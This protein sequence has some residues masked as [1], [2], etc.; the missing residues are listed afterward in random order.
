MKITRGMLLRWLAGVLLTLLIGII[1]LLW[2]RSDFPYYNW[3]YVFGF[4]M[5]ITFFVRRLW[6]WR[7]TSRGSERKLKKYYMIFLVLYLIA[8]ILA[9]ANRMSSPD[10]VLSKVLG[11]IWSLTP[12][13][14]FVWFFISL[15][16][17]V[18]LL[19]L[20]FTAGCILIARLETR[21]RASENIGIG[22]S[23][24]R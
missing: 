16:V 8:L 3:A 6:S 1:L 13:Q 2:R 4:M 15:I 17:L 24:C 20:I 18:I 5:M 11:L 19:V 14:T 23:Q 21:E 12:T 7:P 9:G 22:G 10:S